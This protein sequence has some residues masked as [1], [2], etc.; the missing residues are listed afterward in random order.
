MLRLPY[1]YDATIAKISGHLACNLVKKPSFQ[2]P[3]KSLFTQLSI[4]VKIV[5]TFLSPPVHIAWWA[6]MHRFL[7]VRPSVCHWIIIHISES[8]LIEN[9]TNK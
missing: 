3:T 6:H 4:D 7:S 5:V 9:V 2:N 1:S 8:I